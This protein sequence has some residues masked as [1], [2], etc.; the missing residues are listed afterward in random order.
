MPLPNQLTKS[1]YLDWSDMN[2]LVLKL[3][4]DGDYRLALL[5]GVGCRVALRI[6]D[7]LLLTWT[8]L[9]SE[10]P[11]IKE[12]KTGKIRKITITKQTR[13]LVLRLMPKVK[14]SLNDYAFTNLKGNPLS[15]QYINRVL[16]KSTNKYGLNGQYSSHCFRKTFGRRV[17]QMNG[18][19]EKSLIMLSHLLNHSSIST[20]KIYL[21]IRDV[22]ISNLYESVEL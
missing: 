17:Y 13:D 16:K 10:K 15:I 4:R 7:L 2:N 19:T 5:I 22:E 9:L 20:T 8:Q 6:G 11:E 12:I 1:D 21:G 3:E 14:N 18:E